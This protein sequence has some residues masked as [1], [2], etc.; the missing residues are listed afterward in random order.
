M[1]KKQM[2]N[3]KC[4][5]GK[6]GDRRRDSKEMTVQEFPELQKYVNPNLK[7]MILGRYMVNNEALH[8]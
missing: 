5:K 6:R 7:V 4:L 3:R 2:P 1:E 8:G